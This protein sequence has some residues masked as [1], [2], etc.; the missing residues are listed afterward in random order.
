[1]A[2]DATSRSDDEAAAPAATT[3][4]EASDSSQRTSGNSS[5]GGSEDVK[6]QFLQALQRKQGHQ[7]DGVGRSGPAGSKIHEAH[8]AVGGKR[9]FRRKSGG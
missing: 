6:A 4:N 2:G 3:P 7:N 1:M 9:Q 5:E 8:G